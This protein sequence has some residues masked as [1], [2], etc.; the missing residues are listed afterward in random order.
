MAAKIDFCALI[1]TVFKEGPSEMAALGYK[2]A[3]DLFALKA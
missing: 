3:N 2:A 1:L